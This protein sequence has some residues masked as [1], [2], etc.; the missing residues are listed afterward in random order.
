MNQDISDYQLLNSFA[1]KSHPIITKSILSEKHKK[2]RKSLVWLR[3]LYQSII[4]RFAL[5][6]SVS[7]AFIMLLGVIL[8]DIDSSQA[9]LTWFTVTFGSLTLSIGAASFRQIGRKA[10]E[11]I[12]QLEG[13]DE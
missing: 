10:S 2:E 7:A 11:R 8:F 6:I 5:A 9:F 1:K 3:Q 4:I 12:N 13:I